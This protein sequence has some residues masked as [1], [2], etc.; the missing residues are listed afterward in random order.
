[1]RSCTGVRRQPQKR[2]L[3]LWLP[4]WHL[5]LPAIESLALVKIEP[6]E[7]LCEGNIA[8][9]IAALLFVRRT[10]DGRAVACISAAK[11]RQGL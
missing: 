5:K 4:L 10:F 8:V 1:V 7:K 3:L 6:D 11:E 9:H 2:P